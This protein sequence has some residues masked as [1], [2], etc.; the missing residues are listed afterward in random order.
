MPMPMEDASGILTPED[1]MVG[2]NPTGKNVIVYDDDT[3]T[4]A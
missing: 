3:C 4:W 1:I 2:K